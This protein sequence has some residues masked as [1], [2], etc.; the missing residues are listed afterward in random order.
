M[1]TLNGYLEDKA[2]F[3][4]IAVAASTN[5]DLRKE[6]LAALA[7]ENKN[8]DAR[9]ASH[10]SLL[11]LSDLHPELLY[12]SWDYLVSL[13]Q[14]NSSFPKMSGVYLLANLVR[15]DNE[16]K[17]EAI[18]DLY[19]NLLDDEAVSVAA[20]VAANAAKIAE[21]KPY[22][23][24]DITT[25]L[26]GIDQTHHQ[27]ERQDLIKASAIES[28]ATYFDEAENREEIE[29]FVRNQLMSRSPKTRK[30]AKAFL[31]SIQS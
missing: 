9:H 29:A 15:I 10:Q 16:H 5:A 28:L 31:A 13:L 4:T 2:E 6:L 20:H 18:F 17:F 27:P 12:D 21:A 25:K 22:L 7:P 19:F 1:A 14:A 23:R 30:I 11:I 24:R 8:L 3:S 26:L